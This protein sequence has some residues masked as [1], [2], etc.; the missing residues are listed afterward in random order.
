MSLSNYVKNKI[1]FAHAV[2]LVHLHVSNFKLKAYDSRLK[3]IFIRICNE[4]RKF[5]FCAEINTYAGIF[6]TVW[7]NLGQGGIMLYNVDP[8]NCIVK[9]LHRKLRIV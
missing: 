7:N 6:Y 2:Q 5:L 8:I 3:N 9:F 1:Y 4:F